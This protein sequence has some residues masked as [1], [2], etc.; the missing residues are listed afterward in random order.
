MDN[1]V[2]LQMLDE[3]G[4]PRKD[5]LDRDILVPMKVG[6]KFDSFFSPFRSSPIH[7]G[8][9]RKTGQ[10]DEFVEY[11]IVGASYIIQFGYGIDGVRAVYVYP[12]CDLAKLRT[13]LEPLVIQWKQELV[14]AEE[15]N[16]RQRAQG[17]ICL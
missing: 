1:T 9:F 7:D 14:R 6:E 2:V 8:N 3:V 4:V 11:K 10:A 5:S 17:P 16:A 15:F 12:H 13:V